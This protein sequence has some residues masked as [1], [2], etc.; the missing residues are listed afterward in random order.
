METNDKPPFIYIYI[1]THT[2]N[3]T[4]EFQHALREGFSVPGQLCLIF[5]RGFGTSRRHCGTGRLKTCTSGRHSMTSPHYGRNGGRNFDK[6][7]TKRADLT[8]CAPLTLY[9]R[10]HLLC[11]C[12]CTGPRQCI[13]IYMYMYSFFD[14]CI[15]IY[16]YLDTFNFFYTYDY[17]QIG[18]E[19]T[20]SQ[21]EMAR[22]C[23][24]PDL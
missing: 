6:M 4:F 19:N 18:L 20:V 14:L 21:S 10:S 3:F 23:R 1:Y 9:Y 7:V 5:S 12:I 24:D 16:R 13:Y 15:Y 8:F 2:Y 22:I 17:S 11:A